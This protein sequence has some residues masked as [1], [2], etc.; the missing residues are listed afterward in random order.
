MALTD[1]PQ[2]A[3]GRLLLVD[4]I[5][6]G[7]AAIA[8]AAALSMLHVT[9]RNGMIALGHALMIP[10]P[11]LVRRPGL[12]RVGRLLGD[13]YPILLIAPLYLALDVLHGPGLP[14]VNDALVQSWDK[15]VFGVMWSEEWWRRYP[16]A[17]WSTLL[18]GAY[19][20]YYLIVPAPVAYFLARGD[21]RALRRVILLEMGTFLFCYLWFVFFPVAG[22]YYMFPRPTGVMLD[23]PMAHLVY[24]TLKDGGSFGAAFPSSHVA[25]ATSAV[26]GAWLGDR[27]LGAFLTLPAILLAIGTVYCHMHY[28]IDASTGLLVGIAVPLVLLRVASSEFRV[29]SQGEHVNSE[30]E[31]R[32]S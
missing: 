21:H 17:F 15:A 27:R 26:I 22:P 12:G 9:S 18:H 11:F 19:W 8:T 16:S 10:L 30:L 6:I 4:K 25:A 24:A 14:V 13:I 23:N 7:Y 32:D 28:A 31:T 1:D 29:A 2:A 3:T 20:G 5:I